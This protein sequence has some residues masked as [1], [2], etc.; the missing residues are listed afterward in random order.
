MN[1]N[2][3]KHIE[4]LVDN[5]MKNSKLESPSLD[6][7]NVV[8]AQVNAL[9]KSTVT[10]YQPLI[11]K[12]WWFAIFVMALLVVLF[13]IFGSSTNETNWLSFID[14]S[15]LTDNKLSTALS[16]FK[17]SK[18]VMYS[19]VLFGIMLIIQVPILKNYFDKRIAV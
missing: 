14:I 16:G 8:M 12:P 6:F 18:I 19:V 10:T 7:T 4:K 15:V 1:D 13:I 17:V 11:S 9:Q 5:T 3:D 2:I